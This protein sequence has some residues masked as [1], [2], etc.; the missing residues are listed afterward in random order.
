MIPWQITLKP[1]CPKLCHPKPK[2]TWGIPKRKAP[3]LKGKSE[4]I[5][6]PTI[7]ESDC[8]YLFS[9]F[10]IP[11]HCAKESFHQ[12]FVEGSHMGLMLSTRPKDLNQWIS[13]C[14]KGRPSE[15]GWKK[16]LT[17][18]NEAR[19]FRLMGENMGELFFV[20]AG[21]FYIEGRNYLWRADFFTLSRAVIVFGWGWNFHIGGKLFCSRVFFIEGRIFFFG[22][23]FYSEGQKVM[24]K[25]IQNYHAFVFF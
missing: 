24:T 13:V 17:T 5:L 14:C 3:L 23:D 21:S 22:V 25:G 15:F 9:E 16:H 8:D 4:R 6:P 18:K 10:L 11:R 2:L 7:E 1:L 20:E 12:A 19:F